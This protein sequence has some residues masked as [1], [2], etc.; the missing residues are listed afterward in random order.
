MENE[1]VVLVLIC[2]IIVSCLLISLG[3]VRRVRGDLLMFK[4]IIQDRGI[5]RY[6]EVILLW[7]KYKWKP[8]VIGTAI[9]GLIGSIM[10]YYYSST[11]LVANLIWIVPLIYY[12][13]GAAFGWPK[14]NRIFFLI[15]KDKIEVHYYSENSKPF[16]I[17]WGD[18]SQI[19]TSAGGYGGIDGL[20]IRLE[21]RSF[22]TFDTMSNF[23][24]FCRLIS[25]NFGTE[26]LNDK[27]REYLEKKRRTINYSPTEWP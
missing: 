23:P 8:S 3:I 21:S 24:Q 14:L 26:K 17:K 10:V 2:P 4:K 11:P 22:I 5:S 7:A 9:F 12:A 19:N 27:T 20:E 25:E 6:S 15:D 18:I 16:I 1:I 13:L